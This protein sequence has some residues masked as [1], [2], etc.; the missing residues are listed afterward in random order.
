MEDDWKKL[1]MI[2]NEPQGP[3]TTAGIQSGYNSVLQGPL[4]QDGSSLMSERL[5]MLT[6]NPELSEQYGMNDKMRGYQDQG[7]IAARDSQMKFLDSQS[8]NKNGLFGKGLATMDNLNIV[9]SLLGGF[10]D[11][12]KGWAA[13]KGLKQTERGIDQNI[14]EYQTNLANASTLT[15]NAVREKNNFL[16]AQNMDVKQNYLPTA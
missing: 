16:K 1:L 8:N 5:K 2:N 11:A 13:L 14:L 12:A 6:S 7:E 3:N 15:N 10:G 9:S 4:Q